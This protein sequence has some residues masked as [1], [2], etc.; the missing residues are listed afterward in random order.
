MLHRRIGRI[1][2]SGLLLVFVIAVVVRYSDPAA[3]H[4][5]LSRLFSLSVVLVVVL[6]FGGAILSSLRLK[7]ITADLGYPQSF[8]DAAATPSAGQLAG[9]AFFQFAGQLIG[10]SAIMSRRGIPAAATVV[11]SSLSES[12][13]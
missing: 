5:A 1:A 9:T 4:A 12:W 11:I 13:R 3:V 8:R 6:L 7:L 10:R 2:A